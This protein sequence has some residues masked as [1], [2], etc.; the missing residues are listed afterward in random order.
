MQDIRTRLQKFSLDRQASAS[1]SDC[2]MNSRDSYMELDDSETF[3]SYQQSRNMNFRR[4]T[5]KIYTP[6]FFEKKGD[7]ILKNVRLSSSQNT[8][9]LEK[10]DFEAKALRARKVKRL[11]SPERKYERVDG[12]GVLI[13]EDFHP[14]AFKKESILSATTLVLLILVIISIVAVGLLSSQNF[15]VYINKYIVS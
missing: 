2:S 5:G 13:R 3:Q 6:S 14:D 11:T 12:N 7:F 8:Q 9:R 15:R 10:I 1:S 4:K